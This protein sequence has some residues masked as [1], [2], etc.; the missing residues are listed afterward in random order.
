MNL[1]EEAITGH[2]GERCP[3]HEA[4]CPVCDAW[5]QY[6]ILMA[7]KE[8][9][10]ETPAEPTYEREN[11]RELLKLIFERE[12]DSDMKAF[13]ILADQLPTFDQLENK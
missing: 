6:D 9:W 5:R 1:V 7:G 10:D 4:G 12:Q 2:W 13:A 3:E 8:L 11:R